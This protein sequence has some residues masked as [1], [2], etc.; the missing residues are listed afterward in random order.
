M[1]KADGLYLLEAGVTN[2]RTLP[3]G[4]AGFT[5]SDGEA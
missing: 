3:V 4:W 1:A 5:P 2:I